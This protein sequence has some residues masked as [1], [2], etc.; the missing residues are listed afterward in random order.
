MSNNY[1]LHSFSMP[2]SPN[3]SSFK[4]VTDIGILKRSEIKTNVKLIGS[5]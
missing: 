1:D 3:G 5:I 4:P 2:N